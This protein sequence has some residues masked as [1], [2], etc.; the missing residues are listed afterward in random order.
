MKRNILLAASAMALLSGGAT[1][2]ALAASKVSGAQSLS[3]ALAAHRPIVDPV[4][5]ELHVLLAAGVKSGTFE[6]KRHYAAVLEFYRTRNWHPVWT[7]NGRLTDGA[8]S[9]MDR[10]ERAG[11]DGLDP[12][13]YP[14]PGADFDRDPS[15]TPKRIAEA[16][17]RIAVS[18]LE[19]AEHAQ[20]GRVDPTSISGY[21]KQKP[22]RPDPI[23]VLRTVAA[24]GHPG[25]T[26]AS[27]NPRHRGYVLLREKLA[28]LRASAGGEATLRPVP[29]GEA[30]RIGAID[31]RV[32]L[33]REHLGVAAPEDVEVEFFDDVLSDAVKT[34]QT[35]NGL[36]PDGI[37][38]PRTL[39]AI[40][41]ED[42]D[43]SA[44]DIIANMERWRWLPRRLGRFHVHVNVP[45][46]LVRVKRGGTTVHSTRVVVGKRH[47]QTPIFSDE[48]EHLVVNPYWNVPF[49][50]ASKEMLPQIQRSPG[51]YFARRGYE[52]VRNGRV[53]DPHSV[54][55]T[56]GNL[57]NI[58]IRQRPGAGNALGRIKFMFPNKHSIY[59][60]D[61]PSK[62][63]FK[64]DVRAFS[65]GCVRVQNPLQ[66]ADAILADDR[67][68]NSRRIKKMIGGRERR[69]D[70]ARHIP[71]HITY[72]TTMV[73]EAGEL[74]SKRDIYGHHERLRA[75]LGL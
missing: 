4:A 40:N 58:R 73:N 57:R 69:I 66:F 12:A 74:V 11:E 65:H 45:E 41:G 28:E 31:A 23:G 50:I 10:L 75:A 48:M 51:A 29:A 38:G 20:A 24:S 53:V 42:V 55:W 22:Q 54:Y 14:V 56:A 47:N 71:V 60:H 70:L 37:V 27:Y 2:T 67:Q 44:A 3:P 72:F 64:R 46:F 25:E 33:L 61:T 35:E 43:T 8:L 62:S 19:Y 36:K 16:E 59:L 18:L 63:L 68:W 39:A 1:E 21:F 34:F 17:L 13:A 32:P 52:V 7:D 15:P 5:E 9:V 49:S 30:I 26:L 6:H